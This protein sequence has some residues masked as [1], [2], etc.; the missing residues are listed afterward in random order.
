MDSESDLMARA[1]EGSKEAFS[2]LIRLHHTRIR[3]YLGRYLRRPDV[4]DDVAQD[5]FLDAYRKISEYRGEAPVRYWLLGIA[6]NCLL[7]YLR[8]EERRRHHGVRSLDTVTATLMLRTLS[9]EEERHSDHERQVEALQGCLSTLPEHSSKLIAT[10]YGQRS[11]AV[12]IARQE[13]KKEGAVW[14]AL[15]RLRELLRRCIETRL[16]TAEGV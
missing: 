5:A 8:D 3:A 9:Q 12:D 15:L 10:F 4:V 14:M 6:R 7:R 2:M 13:G 11:T 1:L 16:K